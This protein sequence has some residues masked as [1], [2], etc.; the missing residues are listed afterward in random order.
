MASAPLRRSPLTGSNRHIRSASVSAGAASAADAY[1]ELAK[2]SREQLIEMVGRGR[3]ELGE[4][5][6]KAERAEES[7]GKLVGENEKLGREVEVA[8]GRMGDVLNEQGR[9]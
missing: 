6:E 1:P 4:V 3:V 8:R 9:M 2:C 7:V 5:M